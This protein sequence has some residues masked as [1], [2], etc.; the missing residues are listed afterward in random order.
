MGGFQDGESQ[1]DRNCGNSLDNRSDCFFTFPWRS[2]FSR[3]VDSGSL[4]GDS[5]LPRGK[6]RPHSFE[7]APRTGLRLPKLL[8]REPAII[9]I[10]ICQSAARAGHPDPTRAFKAGTASAAL[11]ELR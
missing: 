5:P 6:D 1:E 9:A 3:V 10:G 7:H 4:Q 11:T 2:Y 8:E